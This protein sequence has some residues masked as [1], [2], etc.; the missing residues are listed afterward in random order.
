MVTMIFEPLTSIFKKEIYIA[1]HNKT[2]SKIS[3]TSVQIKLA[4]LYSKNKAKI[5][6]KIPPILKR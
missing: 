4:T 2:Q 6:T 1:S 5:K 3:I